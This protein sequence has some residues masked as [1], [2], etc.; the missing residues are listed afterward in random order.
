MC[1]LLLYSSTMI[2]TGAIR[3]ANAATVL[4]IVQMRF[5]VKIGCDMR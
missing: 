4:S 3:A 1:G 5:I 2:K